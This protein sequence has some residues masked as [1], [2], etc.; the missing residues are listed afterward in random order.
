MNFSHKVIISQ[1]PQQR[2]RENFKFISI[3]QRV[4]KEQKVHFFKSEDGAQHFLT[5]VQLRKNT[6]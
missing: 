4:T 2:F 6:R 3:Q 1:V 5:T